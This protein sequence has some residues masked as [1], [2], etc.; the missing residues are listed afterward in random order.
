MEKV[1]FV[2]S[3][4]NHANILTKRLEAMPNNREK[5]QLAKIE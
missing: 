2:W 5:E 1:N 4:I 3:I